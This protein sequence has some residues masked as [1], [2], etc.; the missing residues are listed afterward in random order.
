MAV[1]QSRELSYFPE[2]YRY[3]LEWKTVIRQAMDGTETRAALRQR[4]REVFELELL[5][6]DADMR[7]LAADL[8][9]DTGLSWDVPRWHEGYLTTTEA[10]SGGTTVDGSFA[11]HDL[12][13]ADSIFIQPPTEADGVG[14]FHTLSGVA[15][16]TL[17]ISGG[18][19]GTTYPAG[20]RIFAARSCV[21]RQ[22]GSISRYPVNLGTMRMRLVSAEYHPAGGTG[23][24]VDTYQSLPLLDRQPIY[25][26]QQSES[27]AA[28]LIVLDGG[29]GLIDVDT[30]RSHANL[31]RPRKYVIPD[32]DELQWWEKFLD[33]VV[34]MREPFYAPT[35][36]P[37]LVLDSQP[38]S[39]ATTMDIDVSETDYNDAWWDSTFRHLHI[40]TDTDGDVQREVTSIGAESGGVRTLTIGS[41][42]PASGGLQVEK[43][44]F[45]ELSR[46]GSDSV[47]L[48]YRGAYSVL[49]L[50]LQEID[51]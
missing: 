13:E 45:L 20:S 12:D 31:I 43:L 21:R 40:K 28:D 36:T 33:T 3:T 5:P 47:T 24:T 23:A 26:G 51:Q 38:G 32:R 50:V 41:A 17:T 39:G 7:R 25:D 11:D 29:A 35:W 18:T 48:D 10:T 9:N 15:G 27:F 34:G 6:D 46:L 22:D 14:E 1:R 19:W 42:L 30:Y 49:S 44:S 2:A 4:P 8:R 37:D 16:S